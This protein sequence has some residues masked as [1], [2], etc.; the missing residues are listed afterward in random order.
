M[1]GGRPTVSACILAHTSRGGLAR[2]LLELDVVVDEIVVGVDAASRDDTLEIARSGADVVFRFEH[3]GPP[4]RARL[5]PLR[6][7]RGEWILALDE[8]EGLDQA[9]APVLGELV[10]DPRYSHYWFPRRSLVALA[11]PVY[12]HAAPWYPDWQLRLFR[13]HPGRVWH[14]GRIHSGYRV[15]GPGAHEDRTAILHYETLVLSEAERQ[16]KAAAY[17]ALG[18]DES[19]HYHPTAGRERRPLVPGPAA[20][21]PRPRG[22]AGRLLAGVETV[23]ER[24]ATPPWGATLEARMPASARC[25]EALVVEV[26]ARNTGRLD[27]LPPGSSWP[28]LNLSHHLL[29]SSGLVVRRDGERVPMPRVVSPGE[30]VR[31]LL[32]LR[33]PETPG[34][35][36]VEWDLV[37]EGECWFAECGSRTARVPL[38]VGQHAA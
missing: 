4:L 3:V 38:Q 37:S 15:M 28:Y 14:T 29:T 31:F 24:P 36:L 12:L 25:G 17:R 33:A 22:R 23:P 20:A 21:G 6:H 30:S 5:L 35:Y 1:N 19:S 11:P 7:A 13:N 9:I 8:D 34:C 27:W 26:L 16:A 2:L 32:N 18:A 10:A